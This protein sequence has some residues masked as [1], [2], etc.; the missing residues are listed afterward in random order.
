MSAYG[1]EYLD[2]AMRNLGE[3]TDYAVNACGMDL[4]DFWKLFLTTGYAEKFGEGVPRVVSGFS[5]TELA[6]EVLRKAGKKD[7]LPEPQV[8]FTCSREYWSGWILAYYQWY[9]EKKFKEIEAGLPVR[10]VVE[11]Y[12][13]LHE[14]PEDKFVEAADRIIRRKEQGKTR[15]GGS[16]RWRD[17]PKRIFQSNRGLRCGVFSSM[18]REKRRFKKHPQKPCVRLHGHWD[19]RWKICCNC[20][21][22]GQFQFAIAPSPSAD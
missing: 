19:A 9:S 6:E 12:P 2:D 13:A 7:E 20:E 18:N 10:E 11:M 17:I 5:G 8:E 21:G 14:A 4:E 22:I 1:I 16:G 3:M 15:C